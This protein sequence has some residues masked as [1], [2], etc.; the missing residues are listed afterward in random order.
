[1]ARQRRGLQVGCGLLLV[2]ASGCGGAPLPAT[3]PNVLL[4]VWDT[5]R[6]DRVDLH[7]VAGSPTPRLAEWA[8]GARVFEDVVST[9][10]YTVPSHASMFTGLLPSEHCVAH[11]RERLPDAASTLAELLGEAGYRTYLY[12]ENPNI[13][14]DPG[15]NF[16]QGFD[17]AEHPWSARWADEALTIVSAKLEREDRSTR[18]GDRIREAEQGG[19]PP[20]PW[21]LKAAGPLAERALLAWLEDRERERPWFAFLNYMEAHRPTIPPRRY[22][23]RLMSAEDVARSYQV[24]RSWLSMWEYVFGL[25][26]YDDEAL[27]LTRSTY[28][29]ALLEL[30]DLFGNL[31]ESLAAGGWLENTVVILTSDH[32]EHLGEQHMLDHQYSVYEPVLRV[33]LLL[34]FPP[35]VEAGR[36]RRPA[37]NFDVFPT[38]LDLAGLEVPTAT[39]S[40]ARSLLGPAEQAR[41]RLAED[42]VPSRVGV[43]EVVAAHPDFDPT[44]FQRAQRAFT[45]GSWKYLWRSGGPASLYDLADDPLETR[46]LASTEPARAQAMARAL[47]EFHRPRASCR[48]GEE[49]PGPAAESPAT[50]DA[51]RDRLRALGYLEAESGGD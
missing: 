1:M 41:G 37:I 38:I 6:G 48:I 7:G 10:G 2:L 47:E 12:S 30:D 11:G 21:H 35:R 36:D 26:E 13:S 22:R 50:S 27:R 43:A 40:A 44:P 15:R 24:D 42:P 23:E 9:A 25:R 31:L 32:G 34:H 20:T 8:Q 14:A 28:D 33:P 18:L 51:Q 49:G 16:A 4:V 19:P 29:A 17:V 46:D 45:D 5:V 3:G 39:A